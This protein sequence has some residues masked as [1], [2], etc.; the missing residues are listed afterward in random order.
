MLFFR[1][2]LGQTIAV[3]TTN[4]CKWLWSVG[5]FHCATCAIYEYVTQLLCALK[6]LISALKNE[7]TARSRKFY[8]NILQPKLQDMICCNV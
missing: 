7:V 6:E 5:S 2:A 1:N 3:E 8:I 4:S